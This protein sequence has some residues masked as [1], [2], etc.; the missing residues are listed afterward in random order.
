MGEENV[1]SSLSFSWIVVMSES[2]YT[3]LFVSLPALLDCFGEYVML[4]LTP[5][6]YTPD[7][8]VWIYHHL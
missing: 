7:F 2:S 3:S 1:A 4:S 6:R 5:K 8:M